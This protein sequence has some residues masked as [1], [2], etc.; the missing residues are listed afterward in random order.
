[1]NPEETKFEVIVKEREDVGLVNANA[2]GLNVIAPLGF[3]QGV[4]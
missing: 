4:T 1:V 2:G 3:E